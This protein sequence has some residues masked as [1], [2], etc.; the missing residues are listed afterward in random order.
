MVG[1]LPAAELEVYDPVHADLPDVLQ[2]LRADVLPQLHAEA[3]RHVRL[4]VREPVMLSY[5]IKYIML[6]CPLR[7]WRWEGRE[8]KG[9]GGVGRLHI[10][11]L[12]E[13]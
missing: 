12:I 2:P 9:R 3:G 11:Q 5:I 8:G 1:R 6:W 7:R 4:V 13:G 10:Q